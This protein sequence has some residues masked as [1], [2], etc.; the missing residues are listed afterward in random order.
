MSRGYKNR[1]KAIRDLRRE[2]Q[3]EDPEMLRFFASEYNDRWCGF[4]AKLALRDR[5]LS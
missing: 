5:D 4:A 1:R 2:Y 3:K